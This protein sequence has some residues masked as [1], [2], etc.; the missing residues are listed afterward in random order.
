MEKIDEI[1]ACIQ[2]EHHQ[3]VRKT[4][5]SLT[6]L[7]WT[8][9]RKKDARSEKH[10]ALKKYWWVKHP[11]WKEYFLHL[12]W[13]SETASY[14]ELQDI[15]VLFVDFKEL[16]LFHIDKEEK[17]L[18]P[19][20]VQLSEGS[21]DA[22]SFLWPFWKEIQE[23]W[24]QICSENATL[25]KILSQVQLFLESKLDTSSHPLPSQIYLQFQV[26][27]T[28]VLEYVVFEKKVFFEE[29]KQKYPFIA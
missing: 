13:L 19:I 27:H 16:I 11:F 22:E 5:L 26:L 7:F 8:F 1:I 28:Q 3:R 20:L 2:K 10:G 24:C 9:L 17:I 21:K 14:Q 4:L 15:S 23:E 6:F 25:T 12:E 18:F 29:V